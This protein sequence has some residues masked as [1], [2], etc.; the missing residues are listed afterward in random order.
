MYKTEHE[1]TPDYLRTQTF[2]PIM[3]VRLTEK[4]WLDLLV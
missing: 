4:S 3:P 2:F 1:I